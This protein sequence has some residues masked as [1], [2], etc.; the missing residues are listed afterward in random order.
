MACLCRGI[1]NK[2]EEK[3]TYIYDN[4]QFENAKMNFDHLFQYAKKYYNFDYIM[5]ADQDDV[6]LSTKIE[7]TLKKMKNFDKNNKNI[8]MCY[9]G[10]KKLDRV[11]RRC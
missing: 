2:Y 3:I 8:P 6:W 7:K 10:P 4:K 9:N 5:F 11:I 1:N